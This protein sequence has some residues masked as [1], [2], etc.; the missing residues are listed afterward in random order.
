MKDGVILLLVIALAATGFF[1]GMRFIFSHAFKSTPTIERDD[2]YDQM[3]RDQRR[4]MDDL[5]AQQRQNIR[6]QQQRIK[7]LQRK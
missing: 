5:Q 1:M 3:M 2:D 6:D 7:D 4:R